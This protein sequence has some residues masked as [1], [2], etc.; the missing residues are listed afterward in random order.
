MINAIVRVCLLAAFNFFT[1]S[2]VLGQ[3]MSDKTENLIISIDTQDEDGVFY[4][5][6]E[7][8]CYINI[9]N[10]DGIEKDMRID[11]SISTDDWKPL[12]NRS[13]KVKVK[14]NSQS[15]AYC[16]WYDFKDPGFYRYSAKVYNSAGNRVEVAMVIGIEPEALQAPL[17]P[18]DDFMDFWESSIEELRA[19]NPEYK[20]KPIKRKGKTK[21]DLFE[22]EMQSFGGLTVRGWLE[23]PKKKGKYPT[24]IRVPGYTENLLPLDKYD[25]MIVFSFN[26]RDHGESDNS[27]ERGYDMWVRGMESKENYF[28]RGIFLDCIRALDYL[29]SRDDV[30]MEKLAIWGGSQGG[31]LSFAIAAL[32]QRVKLCVADI[33]YMCDYPKYFAI[34]HW[35]EI[36]H[37]FAEDP[38]HTWEM[39][40]NTLSYFDTKYLAKKISCPVLMGVGL[41]DDVCPPSTSFMTYNLIESDKSFVIYKIE[42]HAQPDAH[43]E[44]RFL[45]IREYF[46]ME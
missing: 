36:D 25:D 41:Q 21:T 30:D 7:V 16:P 8:Q 9:N 14:G 17:N 26:T 19:V 6:Q 43:Y 42:Q 10:A 18:P 11:W 46:E 33:P 3:G 38:S 45:E 2:C 27:G 32:D 39:M 5:D 15:K 35:D 44:N 20:I 23:V 12:M 31:G 24:L 4:G 22:V 37:W 28:Y 13:F 34:T 40:Y 29:E 1:L